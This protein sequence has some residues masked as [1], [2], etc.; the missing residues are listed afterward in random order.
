MSR[1]G[2]AA[3]ICLAAACG[4]L[5][6]RDRGR[7]AGVHSPSA[8]D[9][10][11]AGDTLRAA[12]TLP[13]AAESAWAASRARLEP[14][15]LKTVPAA[16]V[17]GWTG[18]GER[19]FEVAGRTSERQAGHARRFGSITLQTALRARP[20]G[21]YPCTSCHLGRKVA[22]A[23]QRIGD[24]HQNIQPEHP[25][26]TGARCATCHAAD[27]VG[28]LTLLNGERATLDQSYRLCAQCHFA[29]VDAWAHGAHGKRLDGWQGRRVVMG[30]PDCH[31]PH[32]PALERRVPFRAPQIE[33]T[34]SD[35]P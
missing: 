24:A 27:D 23:D 19:S 21:Q 32:K 22:M 35:E 11:P 7:P 6:C 10:L 2:R 4:A 34:R 8:A 31:D 18:P 5:G 25:R 16:P 1:A 14:G 28:L 12:D 3:A 33:R 26:Q 9:T 17:E 13:A 15:A 30:C 29:Q 20:L